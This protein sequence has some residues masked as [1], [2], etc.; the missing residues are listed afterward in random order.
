MESIAKMRK[1]NF[2]LSS[3][4]FLSVQTGT[5]SF[6]CAVMFLAC[7]PPDSG[8]P[9]QSIPLMRS[10]KFEAGK[11]GLKEDILGV[12]SN[13]LITVEI[14][15]TELDTFKTVFSKLV[16]SFE[17]A[18][19][20][21]GVMVNGVLQVSERTKPN[22]FD[23]V[24]YSVIDPYNVTEL[25]GKSEKY[26]VVFKSTKA[27]RFYVSANQFRLVLKREHP[28]AFDDEGWLKTDDD[29]LNHV[30]AIVIGGPV[31][32]MEGL[33]YFPALDDLSLVGSE[34]RSIDLSGNPAL[35]FLLIRDDKLS[36]IDLRAN[37]KLE[38]LEFSGNQ[39]RSINLVGNPAL[40]KLD[41]SGNQ[42]RS[43]NL[44]T[45]SELKSLKFDGRKGRLLSSLDLSSNLE[46][47]TLSLEGTQLSS[48][49]LSK[50]FKL[51]RLKLSNSPKLETL[52]IR[53]IR[54]R[55]LSFDNLP[56]LAELKI[57]E[58]SKDHLEIRKLKDIHYEDLNIKTYSRA[59]VGIEYTLK[60][61]NYEPLP[62]PP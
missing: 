47:E 21:T 18:Y 19:G 60:E 39:L 49:N 26:E 56:G 36:D 10:F 58:N 17:V 3:R 23:L 29:S 46:L 5:V 61:W 14:P 62:A 9:D 52:D 2:T 16:P 51:E 32:S 34:L 27:S 42:L 41:L 37:P 28:G 7:Q 8:T 12:I 33:Q 53:G 44:K 4:F 24:V 20:V 48:I 31:R 25:E 6:F 55:E 40:S 35:K 54:G 50:H 15:G 13:G 45:N 30:K 22:F 59:P 38:S 11:N 43:I 1:K 57:S